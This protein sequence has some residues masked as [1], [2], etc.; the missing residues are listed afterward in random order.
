MYVILFMVEIIV[1]VRS[2]TSGM[3]FDSCG[4]CLLGIQDIDVEAQVDS[5]LLNRKRIIGAGASRPHTE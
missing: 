4:W 2:A 1:L 5:P 3:E